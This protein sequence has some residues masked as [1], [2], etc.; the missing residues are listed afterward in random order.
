MLEQKTAILSGDDLRL[1]YMNAMYPHAFSMGVGPLVAIESDGTVKV[2]AE[3][4]TAPRIV[5]VT[6]AE[7]LVYAMTQVLAADA[8][9]KTEYSPSLKTCKIGD[10]VAFGHDYFEAGMRAHLLSQC[11]TSPSA[12]IDEE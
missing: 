1:A 4:D 2:F 9:F 5:V 6:Q 3:N 12:I 8:K 7:Q 10:A 11:K